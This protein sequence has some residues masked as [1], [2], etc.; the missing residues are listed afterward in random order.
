MKIINWIKTYWMSIL[1]TLAMVGVVV[2]IVA[3]MILFPCD[4]NISDC[5]NCTGLI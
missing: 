4:P 5:Y 3:L 1:L 2:L